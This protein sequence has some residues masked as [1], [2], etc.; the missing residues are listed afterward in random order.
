VRYEQAATFDGAAEVAEKKEA[1]MEEVPRPTMQ[2]M[3]KTVQFSTEP[4]VRKH[5]EVSS[6]MESAMVQVINQMNQL[7]LHLLQPRTNKSRNVERDLLTVQCYKC[8]KMGHYSRKCPNSLALA[9]RENASSSIQRFSV[10]K[11]GK[12]QVHLIEPISERREKAL[13]GL[14]KSLQLPEDAMDVMAQAKRPM[15]DSTHPDINIK[16]FKEMV[17]APKTNRRRRFGFQDF[18][19]SRDS[20]P[21]SVV[22]DVGSQKA[23]ITI[24]QLV[25][26]V[27]SARRELRKGLST[28]KVPTV[29]TPLNAIAAKREC[30]PIIDVQCNGS[31][32]RGVLVDGGA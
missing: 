22:K 3:V 5:P 1:S 16:K 26:M 14:E 30:D 18:P 20:G 8:R 10:E 24:G 25:A 6:R 4:K 28:P 9:T 7:S 29:P 32:L 13:M 23:N 19:I 31:V 21:Y 12:A 27:P 11:K 2:T 15:E 17:R